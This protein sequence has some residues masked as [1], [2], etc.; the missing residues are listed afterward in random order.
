V[1]REIKIGDV[2]FMFD[3]NRRVYAKDANG[4]SIGGPLF[5]GHFY[6]VEVYG[7]TSRSWLVGRPGRPALSEWLRPELAAKVPKAKPFPP[8]YTAEDVDRAVWVRENGHRLA[9]R[10]SY[11]KDYDKLRQIAEIVGYE[12]PKP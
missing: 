11:V 8:L 4:R 7:E 6:P 3:S 9:E 10:V 2:F 5:R 1:T 12:E